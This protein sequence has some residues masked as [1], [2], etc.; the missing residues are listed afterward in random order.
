MR[1]YIFVFFFA[2]V[3]AD[4]P[5][6]SIS[7]SGTRLTATCPYDGATVT[8]IGKNP[9]E[10]LS[11]DGKYSENSKEPDFEKHLSCTRGTE[12]DL[13]FYIKV[14]VCENC[15]DLDAPLIVGA[16]VADLLLTGGVIILTY[17]CGRR[18]S[19][20]PPQ[21]S[22]ANPRRGAANPSAPPAPMPDYQPL[23]D[24]TRNRD[25]YA[26]VNKTG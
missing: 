23:S 1:C 10:F 17:A 16:I 18:K 22:T 5:K 8:N 26:T 20:S 21:K 14:K 15:Y 2:A 13:K 6:G 11:Q 4:Q 19:G 7:I 3:A 25:T 12:I 24:F 9:S